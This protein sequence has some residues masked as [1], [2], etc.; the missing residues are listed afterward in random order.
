MSWIA[1]C[2]IWESR[3]ARAASCCPT[4]H[5]STRMAYKR[6]GKTNEKCTCK[7]DRANEFSVNDWKSI[8]IRSASFRC[9][10]GRENGNWAIRMTFAARPLRCARRSGR[11]SSCV[12]KQFRSFGLVKFLH[13]NGYS[14]KETEAVPDKVKLWY[15]HN[16]RG[17]LVVNRCY[18]KKKEF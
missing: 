13:V 11:G 1:A 7:R 12:F 17:L 2:R 8:R 4:R 18:Q 3:P 6:D 15:W 9:R 5:P 14:Q 10:T 16:I